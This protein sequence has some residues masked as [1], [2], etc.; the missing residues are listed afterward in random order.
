[1]STY[2]AL[3]KGADIRLCRSCRRLSENHPRAAADPFQ[4][5]IEPQNAGERCS[6]WMPTPAMPNAPRLDTGE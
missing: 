3:C 4:Q 6:T 1:V 2:F 5:F